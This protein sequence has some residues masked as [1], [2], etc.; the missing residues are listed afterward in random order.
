MS[1]EMNLFKCD[2]RTWATCGSSDHQ[3]SLLG[4]GH[5]PTCPHFVP[6]VRA[7]HLLSELVKGIKWWA[8]Q[9]DGVPDELWDAYREAAFVTTGKWIESEG[10]E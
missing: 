6:T 4:N 1:D 10:R 3:A 8:D 5:H 7:I 9:E 2:C